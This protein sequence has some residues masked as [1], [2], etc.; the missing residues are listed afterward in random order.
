MTEP[1]RAARRCS[2][3]AT[4]LTA[5]YRQAASAM[6]RLL[7]L[8]A[9]RRAKWVVLARRGS[10]CVFGAVGRQPPRQVR[11]R[12]EER[13]DLVPA[14]R[15]RV[16]QGARRRSSSCTGGE[17]APRV[18][19]LPPRR[20]ADRGRPR[21]HRRATAPTLNRRP[22]LVRQRGRPFAP[23][24]VVSRDGTTALLVGDIRGNGRVR[25][26]SSTRSTTIRDRVS[27]DRRRPAGQGHRRRRL[28]APTRSRSSRT[29]TARCC[30]RPALLVL[31]LL[32]IIY[33][34]P[35][36]WLIPLFAVLRS[37]SSPRAR[38]ATG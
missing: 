22:A 29:S 25:A 17:H 18:D 5:P 28:L 23:P 12:R 13:V 35:I 37:P 30:W 21:A 7:T 15:R 11:G 10:S 8:P 4:S 20:R 14:R 33:R 2:T 26:R 31:V 1:D 19:R 38:S 24:R 36:F 27:G 34:S 16:D 9:G 3:D 6:S 32:I